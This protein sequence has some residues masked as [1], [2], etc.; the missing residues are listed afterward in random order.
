MQPDQAATLFE[1]T[2]AVAPGDAYWLE[3]KLIAQNTE[4]GPNR[5]Y[6]S[7]LLSG[8]GKDITKM[9]RDRG[10]RHGGLLLILFTEDALVAAHD[11]CAWEDRCLETGL[12]IGTPADRTFAL[13]NRNGHTSCHCALYPVLFDACAARGSSVP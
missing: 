7:Q 2:D 10:I 4:E 3:V 1:P 9:S 6:T 11:L 13:A 12:A 5:S 8:A